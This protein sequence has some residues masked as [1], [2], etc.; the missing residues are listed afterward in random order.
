MRKL[1]LA[2]L[3]AGAPIAARAAENVAMDL[4][5]MTGG[6]WAICCMK[7]EAKNDEAAASMARAAL[8]DCAQEAGRRVQDCPAILAYIKQRWGY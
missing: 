5:L 3:I 8:R 1:I 7:H 4:C 2:T 6:A